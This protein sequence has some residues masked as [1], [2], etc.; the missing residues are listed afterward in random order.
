MIFSSEKAG[1]AATLAGAPLTAA[2]RNSNIDTAHH[3]YF[4]LYRLTKLF[5]IARAQAARAAS[6]SAGAHSPL[7]PLAPSSEADP[8]RAQSQASC[9]DASAFR[10]R[11]DSA[12]AVDSVGWADES[13][14]VSAAA[15]AGVGAAAD[16][17]ELPGV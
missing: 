15:L 16:S 10:H 1:V 3:R 11:Q 9:P 8:A 4:I 7:V 6:D 14:E 5:C 13:R 12:A 2:A 17:D